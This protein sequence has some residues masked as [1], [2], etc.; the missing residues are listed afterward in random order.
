QWHELAIFYS[1][2][3]NY[4]T[5]IMYSSSWSPP[6]NYYAG[7]NLDRKGRSKDCKD[8]LVPNIPEDGY[9]NYLIVKQSL[10][11]HGKDFMEKLIESLINHPSNFE[12]S[13]IEYESLDFKEFQKRTLALSKYEEV[14]TK[15]LEFIC[16]KSPL[17]FKTGIDR[18]NL[19]FYGL[20]MWKCYYSSYTYKFLPPLEYFLDVTP[21]LCEK[22]FYKSVCVGDILFGKVIDYC[23]ADT[24]ILKIIATGGY[25]HRNLL[26]TNINAELKWDDMKLDE[27]LHPDQNVLL[28]DD[29]EF[30][31]KMW[32]K[33]T[34][35][36]VEVLSTPSTIDGTIDPG[37]TILVGTK[38]I[39]L[40]KLYYKKMEGCKYEVKKFSL[41]IC[42]DE[43][44]SNECPPV[45]KFIENKE[46]H[47]Y[48]DCLMK[49]KMKVNSKHK[50]KWLMNRCLNVNNKFE[51][52]LMNSIQYISPNITEAINKDLK[53]AQNEMWIN[54]ICEK[55]TLLED[56]DYVKATEKAFD[57]E[58]K[59]FNPKK[60]HFMNLRAIF[61]KNLSRYKDALRDTQILVKDADSQPMICEVILEYARERESTQN[62]RESEK[63]YKKY[64]EINPENEEAKQAIKRLKE[65]NSEDGKDPDIEELAKIL[66]LREDKNKFIKEGVFERKN[67]NTWK[68]KC[69]F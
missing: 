31:I 46:E 24:H 8:S 11:F 65:L 12:V 48:D 4:L 30:G 57:E 55:K 32:K 69:L 26:G 38:G 2:I 51:Y 21:N 43:N 64:I 44:S 63:L 58:L 50:P 47:S 14:N 67:K 7:K 37:E 15:L 5:Y 20:F 61:Y 17:I 36:T 68:E 62:F 42:N 59:S 9:F 54:E 10:N 35:L 34:L 56:E 45:L 49:F 16:E 3:K 25:K 29:T 13:N 66:E 19:L 39:A 18:K 28:S 22:E 27:T 1:C 23:G 52:S 33:D 53:K 6:A 60:I 41:G 40:D